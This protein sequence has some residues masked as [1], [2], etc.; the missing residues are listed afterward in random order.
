MSTALSAHIADYNT[1]HTPTTTTTVGVADVY[2]VIDSVESAIN[3]HVV[4]L[5]VGY[6]NSGITQF[7]RLVTVD[8]VASD[9]KIVSDGIGAL[10]YNDSLDVGLSGTTLELKFKNSPANT[11]LTS[12]KVKRIRV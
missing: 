9:I 5:V 4:F 8:I 11:T 1:P 7:S 6:L 12:I 10:P 2:Q 3:K